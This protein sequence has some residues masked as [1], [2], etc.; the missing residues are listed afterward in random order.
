ML[1]T[2]L[3]I[4]PRGRCTHESKCL[5]A[6]AILLILARIARRVHA[7]RRTST[8]PDTGLNVRSCRTSQS[9]DCDPCYLVIVIL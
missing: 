2:C 6:L 3:F 8:S 5:D 4:V 1:V 9:L 7:H